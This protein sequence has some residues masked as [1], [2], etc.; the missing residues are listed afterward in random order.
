MLTWVL[1]LMYMVLGA[2]GNQAV[3]IMPLFAGGCM[4]AGIWLMSAAPLF[5]AVTTQSTDGNDELYDPPS[6]IALD[7]AEA[8]FLLLAA[9]VSALP[10]WLAMKGASGLP[11]E[12]QWAIGAGV[13]LL[14]FPF[15]VLSALEQGAPL[16]I[17]SP[18]LAGS[19]VRCFVPWLAFYIAS[20]AVIAGV[21]WL[22][23]YLA[24]RGSLIAMA[25]IPWLAVGL[26][27]VYMRM[28]GRLGWWIAD[29]M[30]PPAEATGE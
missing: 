27:F 23:L 19:Q 7:F 22:A 1:F 13:W 30:P 18:R 15:V 17:F 12:G 2:M 20:T 26:I 28:L 25:P 29:V 4:L 6:W 16:A 24:S 21:G 5:M 10:A 3:Y 9:A 8:A 11:D 14:V